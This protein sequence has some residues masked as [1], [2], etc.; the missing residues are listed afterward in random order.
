MQSGP[1]LG[2][3]LTLSDNLIPC[4]RGIAQRERSE[5]HSAPRPSPLGTLGLAED[6]LRMLP[7]IPNHVYYVARIG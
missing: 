2:P 3:D 4:R 6:D 7:L 1:L 5:H